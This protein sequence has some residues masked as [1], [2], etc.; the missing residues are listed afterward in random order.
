MNSK[1]S[2]GFEIRTLP[3]SSWHIAR[4]GFLRQGLGVTEFIRKVI[5]ESTNEGMR[6][7]KQLRKKRGKCVCVVRSLNIAEEPWRMPLKIVLL[8]DKEVEL[9]I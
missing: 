8:K 4:F 1:S 7:V 9:F 5:S 3:F 6:G 2:R